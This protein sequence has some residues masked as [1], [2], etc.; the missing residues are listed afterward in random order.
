MTILEAI[1]LGIIQGLTEFIPVSSSG[2]LVIAQHFIKGFTQ[3]GVLFDVTLHLGTLI[4]V[5]LYFRDR[6]IIILKDIKLLGF[7]VL[8]TIPAGLI[9]FLFKKTFEDMFSDVKLVGL[10]LIITGIIIF[11]ADK[12]KKSEKDIKSLTWLDSIIIGFAQAIAIIPGISRSGST[13]SGGI[14]LG[15]DRKTAMEF[16]FLLSIPAILGAAV[17]EAK[18]ATGSDFASVNIIVYLIGL[19][20]AAVIGYLSIKVLLNFL[21]KQKLYFFSI[22]CWIAGMIVLV[23]L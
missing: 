14:F 11:I 7:I 20:V 17:L 23:I 3:P 18:H 21:Q 15:F 6:I 1:I 19:I 5:I 16:S 22:Y 10:M 12:V 4:A 2:H 8:G 9:G 13:I